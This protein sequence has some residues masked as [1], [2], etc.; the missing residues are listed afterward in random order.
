MG[1]AACVCKE[2]RRLVSVMHFVRLLA[3][4]NC[5]TN[6]GGQCHSALDVVGPC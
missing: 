2:K 5:V 1:Y 3:L 4:L 6:V